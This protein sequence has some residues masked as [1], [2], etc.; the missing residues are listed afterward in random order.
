MDSNG[1]GL[2]QLTINKSYDGEPYWANDGNIYFSS[3]RGGVDKHYQ[4]WR[5]RYGVSTLNI[6]SIP[7]ISEV[8][9]EIAPQPTSFTYHTVQEGETITV[10]ARRY[11]VTVKDIV[12][13]NKLMTMTITPGMKLK[14]SAQ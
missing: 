7:S 14:V 3:D 9:T 13:W 10:I 6:K 4:I 1:N 11:G 8:S 5:F 12:K 2:T